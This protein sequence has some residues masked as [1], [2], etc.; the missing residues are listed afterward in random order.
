MQQTWPKLQAF[1]YFKTVPFLRLN[2]A[3]VSGFYFCS[4]QNRQDRKDQYSE[5]KAEQV[6]EQVLQVVN[7]HFTAW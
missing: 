4:T 1:N 2:I 6:N 5:R 7:T 3:S